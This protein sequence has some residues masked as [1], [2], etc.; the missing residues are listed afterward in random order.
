MA[1]PLPQQSIKIE[2][3]PVR[4]DDHLYAVWQRQRN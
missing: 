1:K 4:S 2:H 3:R